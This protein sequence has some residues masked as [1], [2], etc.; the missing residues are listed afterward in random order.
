M[1]SA[2]YESLLVERSGVVE[3]RAFGL[4]GNRKNACGRFNDASALKKAARRLS[5]HCSGVYTTLNR[6]SSDALTEELPVENDYIVGALGVRDEHIDRR[7]WLPFDF[8]STS[9]PKQHP[10]SE[11][12]LDEAAEVASFVKEELSS[13][14][15]PEPILGMSGNG[16]H[17]L[18]AVDLPHTEETAGMIYRLY[19]HLAHHVKV[20]VAPTYGSSIKFDSVCFNPSRI[21]KLYGTKAKK[22]VELEEEGRVFR[23][24]TCSIPKELEPVPV[25]LIKNW[26]MEPGAEKVW[27]NGLRG[28]RKPCSGFDSVGS[29]GKD[30]PKTGKGDYSTMDIVQFFKDLNLYRFELKNEEGKH[31]VYCPWADNHSS[32]QTAHQTDT[33]IWEP[34]P[35]DDER[36]WPVFHCSHEGCSESSPEGKRTFDSLRQKY[37]NATIDKYCQEPFDQVEE[38]QEILG[39]AGL[40]ATHSA[41]PS[42]PNATPEEEPEGSAPSS[43][44]EPDRPKDPPP[45][46]GQLEKPTEGAAKKQAAAKAQQDINKEKQ[47]ATK[48]SS[49]SPLLN[50]NE[51][52]SP[53]EKGG[54]PLSARWRWLVWA[55]PKI[56]RCIKTWGYPDEPMPR[57]EDIL[58]DPTP[59]SL[60]DSTAAPP[61]KRSG[62]SRE[63]VVTGPVKEYD[64][65]G[66]EVKKREM[67]P[68]S[69][70]WDKIGKDG[71]RGNNSKDIH[72]NLVAVL[73][74]QMTYHLG[75]DRLMTQQQVRHTFPVLGGKWL[76][77]GKRRAVY[78][79]NLIF[80]PTKP[81]FDPERQLLN[82]FMGFDPPKE[83]G[84]YPEL[85]L[86]HFFFLCD[87]DSMAYDFTL[88]WHAL[89][90]Q[91]IGTKMESALIFK[92][93]QGTGKNMIFTRIVN[94]IFGRYG[95]TVTATQLA[96]EFN[97]WMACKLFILAN[98]VAT[99]R[100]R[101]DIQNKLKSWITDED[102]Q[103]NAKFKDQLAQKN[104]ANMVFLSNMNNPVTIEDNDRRYLV[105]ETREVKPASYFKALGRE[106][107]AGG[108]YGF[109]HLMMERSLGDFT[110][111]TKPPM[112]K[113]KADCISDRMPP[114][115]KFLDRVLKNDVEMPIK[116]LVHTG[117][118]LKEDLWTA[119]GIWKKY[120]G[121][122]SDWCT[123]GVFF[124]KADRVLGER[125]T[126]NVRIEKESGRKVRTKRTY[127]IL[128]QARNLSSQEIHLSA[129][130]FGNCVAANA[131]SSGPRESVELFSTEDVVD[132][133]FTKKD[134]VG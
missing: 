85:I 25:E 110:R 68:E 61:P 32:D 58:E 18:Y 4:G 40:S 56:Y 27:L 97:E 43:V 104:F 117:C 126:I 19:L 84:V 133:G 79:E 49:F 93:V 127:Y 107:E 89:Q 8:D 13:Q 113:A 24:A 63:K 29:S 20:L 41:P 59:K 129:Q 36:L 109:Y 120:H 33:V 111:H 7:L 78:A 42:P 102:I 34:D 96:S 54:V 88:N 66:N 47:E 112:T 65:A 52:D 86:K 38:A 51:D 46:T 22:G 108:I 73:G 15:W 92:G 28:P 122:K 130:H 87:H 23:E 2:T 3:L 57:D 116:D 119:F 95:T 128:P 98:E 123:S 76:T 37:G 64:S 14:G 12:E 67:V 77:S 106:I 31:S 74:S 83:K 45:P 100:D 55:G 75:W 16:Q 70:D 71:D 94:D 91:Q 10:A 9:R 50:L 99:K 44:P 69:E 21:W 35:E 103:I 115:D 134:T 132:L 72:K 39:E 81:K 80:D 48:A 121:Y 17:L 53:G 62:R 1:A 131:L 114:Q 6:I 11:A 26:A 82:R 60:V 124:H 101:V 5:G 125:K 105:N 118:F 90:W 30:R